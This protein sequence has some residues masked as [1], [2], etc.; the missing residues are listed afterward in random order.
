MAGEGYQAN[1]VTWSQQTFVDPAT[2]QLYT[3]DP[4]TGQSVWLIDPTNGLP[5]Q[6]PTQPWGPEGGQVTFTL[7]VQQ[8]G[9]L[10]AGAKT[11]NKHVFV[12]VFTFLLGYLGVD[13]FVRG[14]VGLGIL[15]L[16]TAS[17][18]GVWFLVDWIIGLVKAYG[19]AFGS[20]EDFVFV[21]GQYY[22]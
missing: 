13:R 10:P 1:N 11:I 19:S 20:V 16:F 2:N 15:K 8:V 18:L 7:N 14:Q 4:N 21:N 3:I 6:A 22:R 12:W 9:P 5:L 17:G